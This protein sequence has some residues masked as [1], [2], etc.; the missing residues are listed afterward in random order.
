M[1]PVGWF[2]IAVSDM[3]RAVPFYEKTLDIKLDLQDFGGQ[4]MAWFPVEKGE[5]YGATGSLVEGTAG[6]SGTVVYFS[7]ASIEAVLGRVEESAV[8][9]PKTDIGEFG[10]FA[11]I[12]DSEGNTIG[13]HCQN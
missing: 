5:V 6:N 4:K 10:F 13:L 8:L 3:E 12:Q 7:V 1:N 2:E 11:Q 9:I